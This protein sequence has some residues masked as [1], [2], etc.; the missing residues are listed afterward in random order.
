MQTKLPIAEADRT[1]FTL[2]VLKPKVSISRGKKGGS[3]LVASY[4]N[5]SYAA[6][7]KLAALS[8]STIYFSIGASISS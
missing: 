1:R 6:I 2:V 4:E 5:N 3:K 8:F 7:N